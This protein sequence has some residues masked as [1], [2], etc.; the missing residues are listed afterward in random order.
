MNQPL[1]KA[2]EDD[3]SDYAWDVEISVDV[4]ARVERLETGQFTRL[5]LYE[6]LLELIAV[7]EAYWRGLSPEH[8]QTTA[9]KVRDLLRKF[10]ALKER[11]Q[12]WAARELRKLPSINLAELE[13][14]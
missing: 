14:W 9:R 7:L 12:T 1:L 13:G 11:M 2:L 10:E 3:D 6:E 4:R 5:E 8:Q